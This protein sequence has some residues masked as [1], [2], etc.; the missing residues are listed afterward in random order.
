MGDVVTDWEHLHALHDAID[1]VVH[2]LIRAKRQEAI[3]ANPDWRILPF[4]PD[5]VFDS[6]ATWHF[7]DNFKET[8]EV[9]GHGTF[10]V[11][12]RIRGTEV[13]DYS[14][15]SGPRAIILECRNRVSTMYYRATGKNKSHIGE[16]WEYVR[17]ERVF[18]EVKSV[19]KWSEV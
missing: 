13:G 17:F 14:D 3:E 19:V 16:D 10:R 15:W 11:F 18:P 12:D 8:F 4:G 1:K 6:E 2:E 7:L 9:E 5:H